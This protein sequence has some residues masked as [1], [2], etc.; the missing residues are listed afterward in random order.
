MKK[1]HILNKYVN[2]LENKSSFKIEEIINICKRK[3]NPKR[4]F[5]FVNSMQGKHIPQSPSKI[6]KMYD[7]LL[8]EIIKNSNLNEKVAIIGF[9]ETATAIGNYIASKLPN[10]IYYTQTTREQFNNRKP[11]IAFEEEHSHATSQALYGH[12]EELKKCNRIIFV[13]DEIST[14]KTILNFI[15]EF[16]KLKIDLKYSVASLLNW[17]NDEWTEVFNRYNIDRYFIVKGKLRALDTKL[18]IETNN[19]IEFNK[20]KE[21]IIVEKGIKLPNPRLGIKL[22]N[23]NEL[24]YSLD[25]LQE[26]IK[27]SKDILVLGTEEYMFWPMLFAQKLESMNSSLNVYFHATTRSPIETSNQSEYALKERYKLRSAYDKNRTTYIYNLSKYD[28][29]FIITDTEPE[30]EFLEDIIGALLYN[31]CKIENITIISK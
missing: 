24:N 16:E 18:D 7:E 6:L 3:N 29:V 13:E 8:N 17:Q 26:L 11:L 22:P 5:V 21:K 10:C 4:D 14:G 12:L 19:E 27:D 1:I 28:H 2:D 9:A 25:N 31:K 15:K 20:Y 30:K 23:K